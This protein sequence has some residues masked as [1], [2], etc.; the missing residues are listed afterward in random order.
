MPV[1]TAGK[2]VVIEGRLVPRNDEE[3]CERTYHVRV[4]ELI[5][6]RN[7]IKLD[8]QVLIHAL[9]GAAQANVVLQLNG[10]L[11]VNQSLEKA[12]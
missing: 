11:M 5:Y 7:V 12:R 8:V 1:R 3:M 10:D 9:E 4:L 6:D 2:V